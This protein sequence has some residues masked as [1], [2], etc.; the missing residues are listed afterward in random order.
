MTRQKARYMYSI[1]ED[2]PGLRQADIARITGFSR[3]V[4]HRLLPTLEHFS[5]LLWE[6]EKGRLYP[7]RQNGG[8]V[9]QNIDD[10]RYRRIL[11]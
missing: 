3:T 8:L 7:Y 9:I 6:D 4:V 1:V 2:N 5:L 10:Y 11:L